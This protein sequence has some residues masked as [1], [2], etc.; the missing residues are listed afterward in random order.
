MLFSYRLYFCLIAVFSIFNNCKR[1]YDNPYDPNTDPEIWMPDNLDISIENNNIV[2]ISWRQK[3]ER[4]DG[5]ILKNDN[6]PN[7]LPFVIE[8]N[9]TS[10]ID[11]S[12]FINQNC[13]IQF[14]Y[15]LK[16]YAGE[17]F[18]NQIFYDNCLPITSVIMLTTSPISNLTTNS[19]YSGGNITNNGGSA[20]LKKGVCYSKSLN[21]LISNSSFTNDGTGF[22][23]YSS[24]LNNLSVNTTYYIRAYALN[25]NDTAYGNEVSFITQSLYSSTLST[26][27]ISNISTNSVQ[28]G[29]N[30]TND[31]GA[32]VSQRGVCWSTSANPTNSNVN[33]LTLDGSGTGNF[34]S[35]VN[36]LNPNTNYHLRAYATNSVGTAYGNELSFTTQ[37]LST[38]T[39]I[40]SIISNILTNGAISGGNITNDGGAAITLRGVCWSNSANPTNTNV[41][42]ITLNGSGI[43][44]FIS[45]V[46][47]LNP[48]TTYYL[49]AYATNSVGTAYGN[50]LSFTTQ[51]LSTPTVITSIISN[52]STNGA[53]SGGNI[54][55]DGG[56]S[57]TQK[58][59]CWSISPNPT[60]TNV[61]Y[62]TINGTGTGNFISNINNLNPNT[63]YYLRAYATNSVGTAYGN[64]ISFTTQSLSIPSLSTTMISNISINSVQLG[65]DV[66][67]NGGASVIQRGVCWSISPSPTI[68][69]INNITTDGSGT[70]TFISN[71]SNLNPNTT[72]YLRAYA[73]NS[74]G[75]AYGNEVS[76]TTLCNLPVVNTVSVNA[77]YY[78]T[79][80]T[81]GDSYNLIACGVVTNE[82]T[83]PI[84]Q[85]MIWLNGGVGLGAVGGYP[86]LNINFCI[87]PLQPQGTY[88]VQ[89]SATNACGTAY[90]SVLTITF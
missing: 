71:V 90:G 89:A 16:A 70:G 83:S 23:L 72:Y 75:T 44:N 33:L 80:P 19:A 69:N 25:D 21:P 6:Y 62:M 47:N 17:N 61:N 14:N 40:T 4:I 37:S 48:N 39:V 45:S 78:S 50:E 41:N 3:E 53:M 82:G 13:G 67:Y 35:S 81:L 29:G 57:I 59:V 86:G 30:I 8:K 54:T 68:S 64:Q 85:V 88:D 15:S 36:N 79:H 1:V 43:G 65:G 5:F 27:V 74:I 51:S 38:P 52:I 66:T 49:R 77:T 11:S 34:I 9:D 22:G 76:F 32:A 56:A 55:N 84:S 60:N 7:S 10:F 87:N 73:T 46:S 20:I 58:G 26:A 42:Y 31:G 18:S 2:K 28:T 12:I 24:Y 63:T